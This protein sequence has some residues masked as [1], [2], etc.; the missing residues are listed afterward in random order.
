MLTDAMVRGA[1]PQEKTAR[2]Y[3]ERGLYLEI[4]PAGGRWWRWK[5]R[6][7]GKEKRLSLGVYPDVSLREARL[8][9]DEARKVLAAG[10]DPG[11]A[12]KQAKQ[13]AGATFESVAREWLEVRRPG[14]SAGH[15]ERNHSRLAR[16][17]F[18]FL[19]RV[20]VAEI[21]A[22]AILEVLRRIEARGTV[23]AAHRVRALIAQALDYALQSGRATDNPARSL[24]GA[25]RPATERHFAA[26]TTPQT[27]RKV[28]IALDAYRGTPA[29]E[30]ALRLAPLVV[31][32]PGELRA[33][34]WADVDIQAKEWRFRVSKTAIDHTVPLC[35]QA[36]EVLERLRPVTGHGLFVF[37]N[38]RARGRP[39]SESAVQAALRGAGLLREEASGHGFRASFRTIADEVLGE[40]PDLLEH[41]LAH[42]VRDPLGRSYNRTTFMAER[43]KMMQRWG[44][45]LDTLRQGA[46]IIP[47]CKIKPR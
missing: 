14:W 39:M 3:D 17:A 9:R 44:D 36:L 4:S 22:A 33:M 19:G 35:R 21:T 47:I 15:A 6:A 37:P 27:L 24:R 13:A 12:R 31:V 20:P 30:A 25:L 16:L 2:L 45:Y 11:E 38:A 46:K 28:L 26:A 42:R 8:K 10:L 29:I 5:Y 43:H 41:Q 23:D 34:R 40:R 7:G 18:P 32:R 1:K